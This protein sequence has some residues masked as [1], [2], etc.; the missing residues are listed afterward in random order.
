[1]WKARPSRV[2][3][4]WTVSKVGRRWAPQPASDAKT[5]LPATKRLE[6]PTAGG[7]QLDVLMDKL[8]W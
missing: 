7:G 5:V 4:P 3:T 8:G 1:M 6:V 2:H